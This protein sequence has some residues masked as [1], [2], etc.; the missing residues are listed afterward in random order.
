MDAIDTEVAEPV[1]DVDKPLLMAVEG[2]FYNY[3]TWYCCNWKNRAWNESRSVKKLKSL[4]LE[5]LRKTTC[6][7]VEMFR[8]ELGEGQAGDNVGILLRGLK[9]LIS[10]EVMYLLHQVA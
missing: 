8:K 5:N 9:K 10:R 3:W 4:V 6:T 7:G 2:C 1:R